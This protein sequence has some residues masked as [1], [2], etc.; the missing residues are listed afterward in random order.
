MNVSLQQIVNNIFGYEATLVMKDTEGE[1]E[2][3]DAL[4]A[5]MPPGEVHVDMTRV[6]DALTARERETTPPRPTY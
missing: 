2:V 1:F 3:R 4:I 5:D 6:S